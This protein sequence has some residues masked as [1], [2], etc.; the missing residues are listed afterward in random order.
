MSERDSALRAALKRSQR[1][2]HLPAFD[3]VWSAAQASRRGQFA[4]VLLAAAVLVTTAWLLVA[5]VKPWA[6]P[7]HAKAVLPTAAPLVVPPVVLALSDW[8][9]PTDFLLETPGLEL[10]ATVP[11]VGELPELPNMDLQ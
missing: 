8:R 6:E 7:L 2:T 10:M 9:A 5:S 1:S 11:V 3:E 4:R